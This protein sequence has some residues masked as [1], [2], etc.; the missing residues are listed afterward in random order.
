MFVVKQAKEPC[1]KFAFIILYVIQLFMHRF[2]I[3]FTYVPR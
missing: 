3:L 2:Q 1:Y